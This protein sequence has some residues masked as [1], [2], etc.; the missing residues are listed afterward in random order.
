MQ[1]RLLEQYHEDK[2]HRHI[3]RPTGAAI[4]RPFII[5]SCYANQPQGTVS[6]PDRQGNGCSPTCMTKQHRAHHPLPLPLG[7][8]SEQSEDGEGE[9]LQGEKQRLCR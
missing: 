9:P 7:E 1:K 5:S 8:V 6:R 4:G 2:K 3:T